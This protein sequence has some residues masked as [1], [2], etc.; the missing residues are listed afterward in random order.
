[1]VV[2][3]HTDFPELLLLRDHHSWPQMQFVVV[4]VPGS[5]LGHFPCAGNG[6]NLSFSP[7]RITLGKDPKPGLRHL[8]PVIEH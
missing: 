8:S 7:L 2:N 6:V 1:M 4:A 3:P 5:V